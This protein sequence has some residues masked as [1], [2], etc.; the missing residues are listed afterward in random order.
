MTEEEMDELID[1]ERTKNYFN[2]QDLEED[3]EEE[4]NHYFTK[5][6]EFMERRQ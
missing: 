2:H 5:E 4:I 1:F 3:P 6:S